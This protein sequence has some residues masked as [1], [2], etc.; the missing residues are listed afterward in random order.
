MVAAIARAQPV[1]DAGLATP[2]GHAARL[3]VGHVAVDRAHRHFQP[4]GQLFGGGQ[5]PAAQALHQLE[6]AVGTAHRRRAIRRR[7]AGRRVASLSWMLREHAHAVGQ[8][9]LRRQQLAAGLFQPAAASA[10]SV[11]WHPGRE[12]PVASS[13]PGA[14]RQPPTPGCS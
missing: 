4:A 12:P 8:R 3:Q 5:P 14:I 11:A 9:D 13:R 6:Q 2:D 10:S 1:A 7:R